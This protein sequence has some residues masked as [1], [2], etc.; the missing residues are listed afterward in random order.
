[1][2]IDKALISKLE[3]LARLHLD[4]SERQSIQNDLNNILKMVEKLNEVDTEGQ[5][6]LIHISNEANVLRPD[7][8]KNQLSRDE[9]LKNAPL[10][11]GQFFKV[12]KVIKK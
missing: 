4:E 6:P 11:D 1:M 10:H 7:E 5:E 9:A 8:I 12:P 3:K 2:Q